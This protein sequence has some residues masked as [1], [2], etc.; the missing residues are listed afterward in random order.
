MAPLIPL[1]GRLKGFDLAAD[2]IK[3]DLLNSASNLSKSVN[4]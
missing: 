4:S 3:K 2:V 1:L